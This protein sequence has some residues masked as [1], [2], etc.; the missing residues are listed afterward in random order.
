MPDKIG[1]TL[2]R[3]L[4]VGA[5]LASLGVFLFGAGGAWY[6][7]K[8]S[9][10]FVKTELVEIKLA[11]KATDNRILAMDA[12]IDERID[13]ALLKGVVRTEKCETTRRDLNSHLER[14]DP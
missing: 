12:R 3:V 11:Q 8:T 14:H 6:T 4:K 1:W 10:D 9:L 2:E 5:V 13:A 7:L